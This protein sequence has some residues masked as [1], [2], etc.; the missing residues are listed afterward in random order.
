M[1]KL[2]HDITEA[3]DHLR[4][5]RQ[6]GDRHRIATTRG[7]LDRLLDTWATQHHTHTGT[8]AGNP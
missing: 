1:T 5:A 3:L 4:Q 8:P 7:R 6:Q 2:E